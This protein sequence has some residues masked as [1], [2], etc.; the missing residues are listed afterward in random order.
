M[1]IKE[2][3]NKK[4]IMQIFITISILLISIF[5]IFGKNGNTIQEIIVW[6]TIML[7]LIICSAKKEFIASKFLMN[8]GYFIVFSA[9]SIIWSQHIGGACVR[10]LDMVKTFLFILV[11]LSS[12]KN[13]D[14]IMKYLNI[15]LI[16]VV[17]I[18]VFCIIK[19]FASL[20]V[21]ARLGRDEFETAGQTQ[22]YYSCI[23]IYATI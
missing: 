22:I 11:L 12:C 3:N 17:F 14:D 2:E 5:P 10:V 18:S 21:W 13:K 15:Y 4:N 9:I 19:D 23:L 7:G 1:I 6:I 8:Y 20:Q 16:G